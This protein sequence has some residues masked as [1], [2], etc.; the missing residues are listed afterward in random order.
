MTNTPGYGVYSSYAKTWNELGNQT[1]YVDNY[2]NHTPQNS[3]VTKS[4]N[5]Q[6]VMYLT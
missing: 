3:N 1:G 2:G 4:L 5:I 6:Q